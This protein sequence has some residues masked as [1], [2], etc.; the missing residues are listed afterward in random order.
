MHPPPGRVWSFD[1]LSADAG[2]ASQKEER[3]K[4]SE[5]D[6]MDECECAGYLAEGQ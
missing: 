3:V 1:R 6:G 2:H 4:G 5:I